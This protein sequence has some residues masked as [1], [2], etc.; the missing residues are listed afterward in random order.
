[1]TSLEVRDGEGVVADTR[2]RVCSP[3]LL[4]RS[5]TAATGQRFNDV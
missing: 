2:G 5:Q 4:R 3:D 1:V